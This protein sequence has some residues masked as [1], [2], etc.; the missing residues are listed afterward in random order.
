MCK[1]GSSKVQFA[2]SEPL[3]SISAPK[4]ATVTNSK[5]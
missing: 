3:C 2:M 1:P 5:R 4:L